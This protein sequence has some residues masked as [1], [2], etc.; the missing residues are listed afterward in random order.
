MLQ[1]DSISCLHHMLQLTFIGHLLIIY[2]QGVCDSRHQCHT[3]KGQV[4]TCPPFLKSTVYVTHYA[5]DS[6]SRTAHSSTVMTLRRIAAQSTAHAPTDGQVSSCTIHYTHQLCTHLCQ[7][8]TLHTD[9]L[10][11]N[12][13]K[14]DV[15]H[16]Q[17]HKLAIEH[18]TVD[19]ASA[20]IIKMQIL[21]AFLPG[22]TSRRRPRHKLPVLP[23]PWR[24][25][26][27]RSVRPGCR[28]LISNIS[29]NDC[30]RGRPR[31]QSLHSPPLPHTLSLSP[32]SRNPTTSPPS[33]RGSPS[34]GI[35]V[36]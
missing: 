18:S 16:L 15:D 12:S 24:R 19:S 31:M 5:C 36:S 23:S 11:T 3:R 26:T 7:Q 32:S 22:I 27:R 13:H 4:R 29:I 6:T 25:P 10:Y 30:I 20:A 2:C 1:S 35:P 33:R 14:N 17:M 28:S 9:H 8:T 21:S 34:P